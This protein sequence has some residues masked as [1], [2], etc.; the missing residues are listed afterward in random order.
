[1]LNIDLPPV[2][3]VNQTLHVLEPTIAHQNDWILAVVADAVRIRAED[4]IEVRAA[5]AQHHA[6]GAQRLALASERHVAEAAPI[7]QIAEHR[8]QVAVVELPAQA[9]LLWLHGVAAF[10]VVSGESKNT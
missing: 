3:K 2:H 8:L 5:G 10:Y 6:V 1:M 7:E 9:V 4:R